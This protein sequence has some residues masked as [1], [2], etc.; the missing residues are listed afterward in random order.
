VKA[1]LK[2]AIGLIF[3]DWWLA[4]G[5]VLSIVVTY[6]AVSAG[7]EAQL[8]GWLL[9]LLCVGTLL[10]SLGVEYRKKRTK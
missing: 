10:L 1:I 9:V 7:M 8:S 6:L 3:D 2:T 4:V 5:L